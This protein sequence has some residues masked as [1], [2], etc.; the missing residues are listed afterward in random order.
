MVQEAENGELISVADPYIVK[1]R[2]TNILFHQPI[3]GL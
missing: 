1:E 3:N 2:L